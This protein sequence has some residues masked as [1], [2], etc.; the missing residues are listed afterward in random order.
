MRPRS[1]HCC[2]PLC[3]VSA[4]YNSTV[5]FHSFP[6]EEDL[7]KKWIIQ[8]R[9]DDFQVNKNTKVCSVHFRPDDFMEG[10]HL[11]R[12]KKGVFPTLFEWN[13]YQEQ[14]PR[15][16]VWERRERPLT[17]DPD[18]NIDQEDMDFDVERTGHD[19]CSV[20]EAAAVDM[21]LHE[22][23]ELK[24]EIEDLRKQLEQTKIIHRYEQQL[25]SS[26]ATRVKLYIPNSIIVMTQYCKIVVSVTCS[27][28]FLF[29]KL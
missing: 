16:S 4:R 21:V 22:N 28:A 18:S 11:K 29:P 15:L 12:L 17:P 5:S 1:E 13:H 3:V 8:I 19:Y 20:P 23:E 27:S 9:R 6:V 26:T 7:R 25:L 2:V 24:R 10:A 14:P